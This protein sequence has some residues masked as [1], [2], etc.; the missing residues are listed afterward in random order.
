MKFETWLLGNN[1]RDDPI[2]E[3]SR[4][5]IRARKYHHRVPFSDKMGRQFLT[6]EETF[7]LFHPCE[8][9]LK[10]FDDA[11]KEHNAFNERHI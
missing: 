11:L 7:L 1:D 9:A 2:G 10:A 8:R 4:D 3:L 6:I 5:F